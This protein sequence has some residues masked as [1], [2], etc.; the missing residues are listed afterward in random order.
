M[1]RILLLEDDASLIDGL[2]YSLRKNGFDVETVRTVRGAM[3]CLRQSAPYDLLL[4]ESP[5]PTAQALK[6]VRN[7]GQTAAS[8]PLY[9]S[10]PPTRR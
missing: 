1:I 2:E 7:C 4:L 10:Q 3:T 5:C 6:S 8:S 9:F